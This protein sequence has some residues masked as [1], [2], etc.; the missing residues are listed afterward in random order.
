ML[1][2]I[3]AYK[4]LGYTFYIHKVTCPDPALKVDY[5]YE[6][7]EIKILALGGEVSAQL[8]E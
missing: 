5:L 2:D 1:R 7:V 4:L 3:R 6:F 8:N